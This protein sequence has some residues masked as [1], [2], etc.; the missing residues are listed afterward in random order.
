[1]VFTV[2]EVPFVLEFVTW[3]TSKLPYLAESGL[4]GYLLSTINS[5]PPVPLPGL[6]PAVAGLMGAT[7]TLDTHDPAEINKIFKPLNDTIQE[8]WP[9]Q[10]ELIILIQS[11]DTYM[12]YY[13]I[14]YDNGEAGNSAWLVSRFMDKDLLT[15]DALPDALETALVDGG[16]L[17]CYLVA[18]KGVNEAKPRGGSNAV[19]P[20]WRTAY[21]LGSEYTIPRHTVFG[22]RQAMQ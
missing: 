8:R 3:A 15:G 9:G 19:H 18:G 5:P 6:P 10:I 20:A 2:P 22:H 21:V 7:L 16:W 12:E 13:T 14:N 4:S 1:M 17:G 11:Y